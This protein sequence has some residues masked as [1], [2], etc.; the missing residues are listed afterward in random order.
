MVNRP[1]LIAPARRKKDVT[2]MNEYMT[3]TKTID[4][5]HKELLTIADA[6]IEMTRKE[7]REAQIIGR[8]VDRDRIDRLFDLHDKIWE[9]LEAPAKSGLL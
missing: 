2:T 3:I 4:L 6:L 7:E 9:T 8:K 5:T 1:G